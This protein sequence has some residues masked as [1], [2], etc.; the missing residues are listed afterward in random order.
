MGRSQIRHKAG[1]Q[2]AELRSDSSNWRKIDEIE[3]QR[4]QQLDRVEEM[5]SSICEGLSVVKMKLEAGVVSKVLA[6]YQL[7]LVGNER[8]V[9]DSQDR[10]HD[11]V[12]LQRVL[13]LLLH[14]LRRHCVRPDDQHQPLSRIS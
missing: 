3:K 12:R 14:I 6:M 11:L 7:Q 2:F 13:P 4:D 10:R 8:V 5:V 1:E 9:T